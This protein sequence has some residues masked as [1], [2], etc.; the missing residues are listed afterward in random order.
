MTARWD[1]E[2]DDE[3]W[4]KQQSITTLREVYASEPPA[5]VDKSSIKGKIKELMTTRLQENAAAG[6]KNEA[7]NNAYDLLSYVKV[8]D[9]DALQA[10]V[11]DAEGNKHKVKDIVYDVVDSRIRALDGKDDLVSYLQRKALLET[12]KT[13]QKDDADKVRVFDEAIKEE[14]E[15]IEYELSQPREEISDNEFAHYDEADRS[16]ALDDISDEAKNAFIDRLA[17]LSGWSNVDGKVITENDSRLAQSINSLDVYDNDGKLTD[18]YSECAELADKIQFDVPAGTD[19]KKIQGYKQQLL[20]NAAMR[21]TNEVL[22]DRSFVF[23]HKTAKDI[24]NAYKAEIGRQF[25]R[26]VVLAGLAGNEST[27]VMLEQI[28][29]DKDGNIVYTGNKDGIDK[30]IEKI[31]AGKAK[32][33]PLTVEMDRRNLNLENKKISKILRRKQVDENKLSFRQKAQQVVKGAWNN[34][35][36]EGGWKKISLNMVMFGASA[37]MMAGAAPLM[38]TGAALYAGWTAVNAWVAPVYDS[39]AKEMREQGIKG[40]KNRL[41][42][43]KNNWKRAKEEKYK[44]KDFKKRA[45]MRT[46]EGLAVGSVSG[47]GGAFLGAGLGRTLMRQGTMAVGKSTSL[48]STLFSRKK[49][50]E[51]FRQNYTVDNYKAL[52]T[53]EANLR[54]DTTSLFGVVAGAAVTDIVKFGEIDLNGASAEQNTV[55]GGSQTLNDVHQPIN[56]DEN[57]NSIADALERP[58]VT[59]PDENGNGI[60]DYLE[61]QEEP[62]SGSTLEDTTVPGD[63]PAA[64]TDETPAGETPVENGN[65]NAAAGDAANKEDGAGNEGVTE[66]GDNAGNDSTP[67]GEVPPA[68]EENS[69]DFSKL[70][71]NEKRMYLNS[72]KKWDNNALATRIADLEK[73]GMTITPE[74]KDALQ[75]AFG[76]NAFGKQIVQSFYDAID[77]GKVESLPEGVSAVEY[78]DKL[79]RLAQLAPYAQRQAISIMVKDL[80]CEDFHPTD[81]EVALVKTAL[82][83]IVYEKG[84]MEC[85]IPDANGNLCVKTTSMFGQYVGPQQMAQVEVNG[86]MKELPL[87]TAN[88]TTGLEAKV[89]CDEG[90]GR[91]VSTYERHTLKDCGCIKTPE[92]TSVLETRSQDPEPLKPLQEIRGKAETTPDT[93]QEITLNF[94]DPY[95]ESTGTYASGKDNFAVEQTTADGSVKYMRM[96]KDGTLHLWQDNVD[97]NADSRLATGGI[98]VEHH[99]PLSLNMNNLGAAKI[100]D[101][102]NVTTYQYGEGKN[103]LVFSID[104]ESGIV[105]TTIGKQEVILDQKTAQAALANIQKAAEEGKVD[106]VYNYQHGDEAEQTS[107]VAEHAD[108]D[109][110]TRVEE[111]LNDKVEKAV[112]KASR[113]TTEADYQDQQAAKAARIAEIRARQAAVTDSTAADETADSSDN[114]IEPETKVVSAGDNN[115]PTTPETEVSSSLTGSPEKD[116]AAYTDILRGTT[117][118]EATGKYTVDSWRSGKLTYHFNEETNEFNIRRRGFPANGGHILFQNNVEGNV[119]SFDDN[120]YMDISGKEYEGTYDGQNLRGD[121]RQF[122]LRDDVYCH[123]MARQANGET[124]NDLEKSFMAQHEKELDAYG[125]THGENGYLQPKPL[126]EMLDKGYDLVQGNRTVSL[127]DA[128]NA[129]KHEVASAGFKGEYSVLPDGRLAMDAGITEY[130]NPSYTA[131]RDKVGLI[132]KMSD[133]T[134]SDM[135]GRITSDNLGAVDRAK[136]I[137]VMEI[138]KKEAVYQDLLERQSEGE[139]LNAAEQTFMQKHNETLR[140]Y[141]LQHNRSGNFIEAKGNSPVVRSGRSGR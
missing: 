52:Q 18:I 32:L 41:K 21:A 76:D 1:S 5:G 102:E 137:L 113:D 119:Y 71:E 24:M 62:D 117:Y 141:G 48:F 134:F 36:K 61:R 66:K 122:C 31:L 70:N 26:S 22:K 11:T 72:I 109:R 13:I 2:W 124:L 108:K 86:E 38:A 116:S 85:I 114:G 127:A 100:T 49:T 37:S 91:I 82:D 74:I 126:N 87:R 67:E 121:I 103:A 129:V 115:I 6:F 68:A 59:M 63:A 9:E 118:D 78:V 97:L 96:E 33:H 94:K 106:Q 25:E 45:W 83:S 27:G 60:P 133:G 50:K 112:E 56:F 55:V 15:K 136:D 80:L 47:I 77:A 73:E 99:I 130:E 53:V 40:L 16:G 69:F 139:S 128:G 23:R 35:I 42:Y 123:M 28:T 19:A 54:R 105:T 43:L 4:L 101:L 107:A 131:I 3:E 120:T 140:S 110:K 75:D 10:E 81:S 14:R 93:R 30:A 17:Q 44:E 79:T 88:V 132:Q 12:A 34:I 125:Y 64:A 51:E 65:E 39:L 111:G 135:T 20:A 8:V 95:S 57:G 7:E 138:A 46:V 84:S 92:H 90:T 29:R 58:A 104:K 89:N 98:E